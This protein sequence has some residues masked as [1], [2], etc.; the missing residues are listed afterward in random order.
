MQLNIEQQHLYLMRD[1]DRKVQV[2]RVYLVQ[3][4]KLTPKWNYP[5][6]PQTPHIH[7]RYEWFWTGVDRLASLLISVSSLVSITSQLSVLPTL[8]S[9][10]DPIIYLQSVVVPLNCQLLSVP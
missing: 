5:F 7:L 3:T 10:K 9:L 6:N 1:T 4:N 2:Y 8:S